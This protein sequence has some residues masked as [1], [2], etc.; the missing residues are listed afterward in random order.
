MG[1]SGTGRS[2]E[3]GSGEVSDLGRDEGLELTVSVR[4]GCFGRGGHATGGEGFLAGFT[5]SVSRRQ[6]SPEGLG[7]AKVGSRF[8]HLLLPSRPAS[9]SRQCLGKG[10]KQS[11]RSCTSSLPGLSPSQTCCRGC[12]ASWSVLSR[13]GVSVSGT[14]LQAGVSQKRV[15]SRSFRV[16]EIPVTCQPDGAGWAGRTVSLRRGAGCWGEHVCLSAGPGEGVAGSA[17]IVPGRAG[18]ALLL[19]SC[20]GAGGKLG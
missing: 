13:A 9:R 7:R 11:G 19:S 1:L 14:Y 20:S 18:S 12:A 2:R 10:S 5:S 16:A 17:R 4:A 3:P 6:A 15:W 8:P